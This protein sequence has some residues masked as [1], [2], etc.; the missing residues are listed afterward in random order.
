MN[1]FSNIILKLS[2]VFGIGVLFLSAPA[3][4]SVTRSS[5]LERRTETHHTLR[6]RQADKGA[7][8]ADPKQGA[9]TG[10]AGSPA[11]EGAGQL[12]GMLL[13]MGEALDAVT[14]MG[15]NATVVKLASEAVN[16]MIPEMKKARS[17]VMSGITDKEK[18]GESLK[19]ADAASE[20]ITQLLGT[21]TAD[22]DNANVIKKNFPAL[23]EAFGTV[24]SNAEEVVNAAFPNKGGAAAGGAGGSNVTANA[25][26]RN[27]AGDKK[28]K[29]EAK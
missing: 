23:G 13:Q 3:H 16:K 28:P 7:P 11:E 20:K 1:S 24:F 9:G 6:A 14:N 26:Q 22:P 8:P 17:T 25:P 21:I 2:L 29:K 19:K 10:K 4:Q 12:V 5:S 27:T 15:S 18:L